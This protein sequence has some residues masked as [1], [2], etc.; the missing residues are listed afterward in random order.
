[1]E[2]KVNGF[3]VQSLDITKLKSQEI[4]F[5]TLQDIETNTLIKT[6]LGEGKIEKLSINLSSRVCDATLKYETTDEKQ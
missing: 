6:H 3:E 4:R 1:M 2:I 5:A